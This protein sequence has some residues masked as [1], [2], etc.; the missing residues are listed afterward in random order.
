MTAGL[1]VGGL[2]AGYRIESVLGRGGMSVVYLAEHLKLGRKVAL[3]VL[4]SEVAAD[5]SFRERFVRESRVAA[6][7]DH[8]NIVPI[9]EADEADEHLFIAMRYVRGTDLEGLIHDQGPLPVERAIPIVRQV[10]SA[11]D[12]AHAQGL[13]HRDVK[14]ANIL[15]AT[16]AGPGATDH[17]YL[18]D[19]GIT[20]R[21]S[22]QAG[23]TRTG[24][25][26]GTVDYIAPEQIQGSEVDGRTDVYS[27]G[28]VLYKSLT[29]EVPFAR[30]DEIAVLWA[31]LNE[32]PPSVTAVRPDLPA[33]LDTVVATAMAK[34][35]EDRYPTC[36]EMTAEAQREAGVGSMGAAAQ[37]G[38]VRVLRR[39]ARR[40][41][42]A[43]RRPGGRPRRRVLLAAGAVVAVLAVVA[44]VVLATGG[45]PSPTG[46]A[47]TVLR[48]INVQKDQLTSRPV[49]GVRGA[50]GLAVGG[51]EVWVVA[52]RSVVR[53]VPGEAGSRKAVP[54][55][56]NPSDV[57]VA[58]GSVWVSGKQNGG[59]GV[60]ARINPETVAIDS[61]CEEPLP[62]EV[63]RLA[64]S[65]RALWALSGQAGLLTEIDPVSCP[66]GC[67]GHGSGTRTYRGQA[68]RDLS[69]KRH[70]T[71]LCGGD[72]NSV[73]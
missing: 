44:G 48:R 66:T 28:C 8:P 42:A 38:P 57:A 60:V 15:I 12:A 17:A 61:T 19:F 69:Q 32:D 4:A 11:L 7:L 51:G 49:P 59:G 63:D 30:P 56:F 65:P 67:R 35:P 70:D 18:S 73:P 14:P 41:A 10:A 45:G 20:K 37:A 40:A 58:A 9:Y 23:K 62:H 54:L 53:L 27:L 6:G 43:R 26:L 34:A 5:A 71:T 16:G 3:K 39:P 33:G 1:E 29:G 21:L 25:L 64:V 52:P 68:K 72:P 31:H 46:N 47:P 36:G 13:A 50:L 22:Y 24:E 55:D 2:L